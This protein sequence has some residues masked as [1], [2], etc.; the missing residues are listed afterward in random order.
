[1]APLWPLPSASR[2]VGGLG[3]HFG[4]RAPKQYPRPRGRE[5]AAARG[6]GT[7]SDQMD[8]HEKVAAWR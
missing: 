8:W 2:W 5:L 4:A 6:G 1:M 7:Y 3:V